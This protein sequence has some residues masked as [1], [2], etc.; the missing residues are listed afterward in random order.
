MRALVLAGGRSRRMG[1]DKAAMQ[2]D[3][4]SLLART[5]ATA[6]RVS[7][8]VLVSVN[9]DQV[10][11]PVRAQFALLVDPSTDAGPL[12]AIRGALESA[13]DVD[14]LVLG[15]DMPGLDQRTLELLRRAA[16][17]AP[18]APAIAACLPD[19]SLPEPLCAIWRGAMLAHID[20]AL[21]AG[22]RCPRK[23][24]IRAEA[25]TVPVA[26]PRVVANLNTPEDRAAWFAA[27]GESR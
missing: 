24:L 9:P 23:C 6:S 16:A 21:A 8:H 4:E 19:A 1:V 11:D 10:A 22:R 26:S 17:G 7:D 2:V 3:G 18:D 5:V 25:L 13:P 20:A 15:C 27:T 12:G 14:W